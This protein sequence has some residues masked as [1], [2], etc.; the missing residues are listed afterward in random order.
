MMDLETDSSEIVRSL[1]AAKAAI[2]EA[3]G[4]VIPRTFALICDAFNYDATMARVQ[5]IKDARNA[6]RREIYRL[7]KQVLWPA[8]SIHQKSKT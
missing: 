3:L 7:K 2:K 5:E 1:E 8:I 4:D 6:R